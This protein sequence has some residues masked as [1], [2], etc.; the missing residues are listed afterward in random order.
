MTYSEVDRETGKEQDYKLRLASISFKLSE[1]RHDYER[2][3][4][5]FVDLLA[6]FGGFN[7]GLLLVA[8]VLTGG[9]AA[10]M[11]AGSLASTFPI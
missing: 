11:F 5:T 1:T 2:S 8:H 6:D 10:S 7:D 4:Y 9:Y 3:R